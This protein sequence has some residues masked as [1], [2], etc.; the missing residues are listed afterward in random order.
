MKADSGVRAV[1]RLDSG[2]DEALRIA[3]EVLRSLQEIL[4]LKD[5]KVHE[6]IR[7]GKTIIGDAVVK[8]GNSFNGLNAQTRTQ[9]QLV[10]SLIE[11]VSQKKAGGANADRASVREIA[12]GMSI[13][14]QGFMA[15]LGQVSAQRSGVIAKMEAMT[16]VV[17]QTF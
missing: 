14:L 7:R 17:N 15:T 4:A 13:I 2:S 3:A 8:L 1:E 9:Q 16:D 10:S 12:D 5:A 11:E 6:D